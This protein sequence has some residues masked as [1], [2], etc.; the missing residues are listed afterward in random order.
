VIL[1][2]ASRAGA[3]AGKTPNHHARNLRPHDGGAA[4]LLLLAVLKNLTF[5]G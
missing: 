3:L 4:N 1:R 5:A 2:A